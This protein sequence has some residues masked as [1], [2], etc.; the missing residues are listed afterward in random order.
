MSAGTQGRGHQGRDPSPAPD[1]PPPRAQRSRPTDPCDRP[2]HRGGAEDRPRAMLQPSTCPLTDRSGSWDIEDCR[3]P[4]ARA[5]AGKSAALLQRCQPRP[6]RA[7]QRSAR[8]A[9]RPWPGVF[10]RARRFRDPGRA[11][12]IRRTSRSANTAC[13]SS[14]RADVSRLGARIVG[15][16]RCRS[17]AGPAPGRQAKADTTWSVLG[18]SET[19][20]FRSDPRFNTH[21]GQNKNTPLSGVQN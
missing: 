8:D 21:R 9:S 17:G 11:R 7:Q 1:P 14:P 12:E 10:C 3:R 15:I 18:G 19:V 13:D 6:L 5:P 16:S 2:A 20:C 4:A